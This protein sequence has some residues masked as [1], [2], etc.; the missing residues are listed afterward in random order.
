M[1]RLKNLSALFL[2][3]FFIPTISFGQ[4]KIQYEIATSVNS[5]LGGGY[6]SI[7]VK[8]RAK[9]YDR[10][11]RY[12]LTGFTHRNEPNSEYTHY[13]YNGT[14]AFAKNIDEEFCTTG[15]T[16]VRMDFD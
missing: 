3:F 9:R 16:Q 11:W 5:I 2:V 1:K 12:G 4:D 13:F 10:F 15:Q 14:H 7:L 8:K 6:P